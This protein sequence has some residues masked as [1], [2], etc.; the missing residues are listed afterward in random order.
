TGVGPG[1]QDGVPTGL[2]TGAA[3]NRSRTLRI[4]VVAVAAVLLVAAGVLI[5]PSLFGGRAQAVRLEPDATLDLTA[6]PQ[7]DLDDAFTTDTAARYAPHQPFPKEARPQI[8]VG[9]GR[10]TGS[11]AEPYFTL[12]AGPARLPAD[13]AVSVL[14]IGSFAGTGQPEDS[15]FVGWVKNHDSYITAW[16]NNTR[17]TTGFDLRVGGE[18]RAVPGEIPLGLAPGDRL[19]VLLTRDRAT[20]YVEHAGTWRRLHTAFVADLFATAQARQGYHYGFGLRGTTGTSSVA[21]FEGRSLP[22]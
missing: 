7:V 8:N 4:A 10:F 5:V 13:Q 18:F 11:R 12:L 19:A 2:P 20:S 16:Y 1:T 17:K 6:L 3:H 9:A 15:V 21:H 22:N 14:T